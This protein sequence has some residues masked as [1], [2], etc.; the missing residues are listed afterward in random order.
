MTTNNIKTILFASL[1]AVML[2]PFNVMGEAQ[3]ENVYTRAQ[4]DKAFARGDSNI[5]FDEN[6]KIN[7]DLRGM[8]RSGLSTSDIMIVNEYAHLNNALVEA[9]INEDENAIELAG[10]NLI[11]G[12]FAYVFDDPTYDET[13]M[14][15]QGYWDS[16]ACGI[17]N[18]VTSTYP[19]TPDLYIGTTG[20]ANQA[21]I[22]TWLT[23]NGQHIVNWPFADWG[24]LVYAEK[25]FTGQEECDNGEFRDEWNVYNPPG[26]HIVNGVTSSGWYTL[27]HDNE[28]KS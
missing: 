26:S 27:N 4:V 25:N 17:T 24:D 20:H 18:G 7:V 6:N 12:K 8:A 13:Q 1:I 11:E 16:S 19:D 2:L 10:T 3:A 5:T 14:S 28:P 15:I 23:N 21:A 9:M 22:E